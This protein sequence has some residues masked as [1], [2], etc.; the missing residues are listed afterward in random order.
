MKNESGRYNKTLLGNLLMITWEMTRSCNLA[1]VHCRASSVHAPYKSELDTA[2]CKALLDDISNFSHPV[3]ILTGGEPLL[4]EDIFE[5]AA[6]GSG[7]GLRMVLSTNGT[8]IT[9][10][11]TRKIIDSGIKRVSV[12]IDGNDA[13]SHDSFRGVPGAFERA[14]RGIECMKKIGMDFQI[15]TTITR[16][17]IHKIADILNMALRLEAVGHHI[18]MLVPMGRGKDFS[19]QDI[20][21]AEYERILE[22][23]QGQGSRTH[24]QLRATCAPQYFRILHQ[25]TG[26]AQTGFSHQPHTM[27]RGC[28]GGISFCFISHTGQVQPCGYLELDC[29]QIRSLPFREIWEESPVFHELRDL[30]KYKGKCG[31]CEFNK[32]CG[33]CRARAYAQT[34]D[35][36]QEEPLC[37]YKP[38]EW[39]ARG[40]DNRGTS[41]DKKLEWDNKGPSICIE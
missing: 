10:E 27:A 31:R 32:I 25:N 11:I 33:G 6:H 4:R 22:W 34:G 20:S 1:C 2:E 12:S 8:L 41:Q 5:I 26:T 24:L 30:N 35:F 28:A 14:L 7:L 13:N 18:F 21:A 38:Q 36:L 40:L 19:G 37:V 15:N 23:F 39:P 29:G 9:D 17:N 3:I 16:A